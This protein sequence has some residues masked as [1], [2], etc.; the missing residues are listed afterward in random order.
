MFNSEKI[1][2]LEEKVTI[3]DKSIKSLEEEIHNLKRQNI[4]DKQDFESKVRLAEQEISIKVAKEVAETKK[5]N[6]ELEKQ[7]A[8]MKKEISI[9]EKAFENMGFDVKDMK[10]ILDQLVKGIV[11]K[12]TVNVI[13]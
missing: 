2:S 4:S 11:S 13:K 7:N 10:D 12:N 5:E 6:Q 1:K 3:K 8:V 9:L